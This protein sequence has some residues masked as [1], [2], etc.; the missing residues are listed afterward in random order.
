ML[1]AH[2]I[3]G[4]APVTPLVSLLPLQKTL[5]VELEEFSPSL[6]AFGLGHRSSRGA[7]RGLAARDSCRQHCCRTRDRNSRHCCC[8]RKGSHRNVASKRSVVDSDPTW[9]PEDAQLSSTAGIPNLEE[10]LEKYLASSGQDADTS[11]ILMDTEEQSSKQLELPWWQRKVTKHLE[12]KWIQTAGI[13][14]KARKSLYQKYVIGYQDKELRY[15]ENMLWRAAG[16]LVYHLR[17]DGELLVLLG[18]PDHSGDSRARSKGRYNTWNLLGG[19]REVEDGTAVD[20]A[21]REMM[22]ESAGLLSAE[23]LM[24]EADNVIWYPNGKYAVFPRQVEGLEDLPTKFA[25][26][27][28]KKWKRSSGLPRPTLDLAWVALTDIM[29]PAAS[30]RKHIFLKGLLKQPA[31]L[32]WLLSKRQTHREAIGLAACQSGDWE[33]TAAR[34]EQQ[35]KQQQ[36]EQEWLQQ[37]ELV[38]AAPAALV[39]GSD[40]DDGNVTDDDDDDT[41]DDDDDDDNGAIATDSEDDDE[42]LAA[43]EAAEQEDERIEGEQR[44]SVAAVGTPLCQLAVDESRYGFAAVLPSRVTHAL[45]A[46]NSRSRMRFRAARARARWRVAVSDAF[47]G[48]P[49]QYKGPAG[50][51]AP[52]MFRGLSGPRNVTQALLVAFA[53][54]LPSTLMVFAQML[55]CLYEDAYKLQLKGAT[56]QEAQQLLGHHQVAQEVVRITVVL[57]LRHALLLLGRGVSASEVVSEVMAENNTHEDSQGA[58][59]AATLLLTAN[60]PSTPSSDTAKLDAHGRKLPRRDRS[61]KAQTLLRKKLRIAVAD[62]MAGRLGASAGM[63]WND[64]AMEGS[65]R[66]LAALP[67]GDIIMFCKVA[68]FGLR[69]RWGRTVM[70]ASDDAWRR[71]I[72]A[73]LLLMSDDAYSVHLR[74]KLKSGS[75]HTASFDA[76]KAALLNTLEIRRIGRSLKA[77]SSFSVDIPQPAEVS[78]FKEALLAANSSTTTGVRKLGAA[79]LEAL[80]DRM[81][82]S[83]LRSNGMDD[84]LG[85][86]ADASTD[87]TD[88]SALRKAMRSDPGGQ[89]YNAPYGKQPALWWVVPEETCKPAVAQAGQASGEA[90]GLSQSIHRG[91]PMVD[92]GRLKRA[93]RQYSKGLE[94]PPGALL[95]DSRSEMGTALERCLTLVDPSYVNTLHDYFETAVQG[96]DVLKRAGRLKAAVTYSPMF[97][98][99]YRERTRITIILQLR[100]TLSKLVPTTPVAVLKAMDDALPPT[101]DLGKRSGTKLLDAGYATLAAEE[102]SVTEAKAGSI[103]AQTKGGSGIWGGMLSAFSNVAGSKANQAD[104]TAEATRQA[105]QALSILRC[106]YAAVGQVGD[107]KP[108]TIIPANVASEVVRLLPEEVVRLTLRMAATAL[109]KNM[110]GPAEVIPPSGTEEEAAFLTA[111][112]K[113][114][115]DFDKYQQQMSTPAGRAKLEQNLDWLLA[116]VKKRGKK[117]GN[118]SGLK[119]F[120]K[121]T[122]SAKGFGKPKRK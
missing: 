93:V 101:A 102:A 67:A 42:M 38:A 3:R 65:L 46:T 1:G 87:L 62:M 79:Q 53:N 30:M 71:A 120:S 97:M 17:R 24:G 4:W 89:P 107:D 113:T 47:V 27:K 90:C 95:W 86:M 115:P 44:D 121:S 61:E 57:Q 55:D 56:A 7:S 106:G 5:T 10:L 60:M 40:I 29:D 15:P 80:A 111:F 8:A 52:M 118:K 41:D 20:T 69:R 76:D 74:M 110:T 35:Q 73:E 16:N 9:P 68:L 59:L 37:A 12:Q 21:C 63:P 103:R 54:T 114:A 82:A 51:E 50:W 96:M 2:T 28:R 88:L 104:K 75:S 81:A 116:A 112:L 85:A 31:L 19:K 45:E 98:S 43:V 66:Q 49:T 83:Y 109:A 122:S 11:L 26:L 33:S 91:E 108:G 18:K 48:A 6:H 94:A 119:G 13:T 58:S 72:V 22:E 32:T 105:I 39:G 84:P 34:D 23:D 14:V 117:S 25:A 92:E 78:R 36:Q 100:Y 70:P 99:L 64:D 77:G